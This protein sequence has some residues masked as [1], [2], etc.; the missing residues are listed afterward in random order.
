MAVTGV[1]TPLSEPWA[2]A[3]PRLS[4]VPFCSA[5]QA[6]VSCGVTVTPTMGDFSLVVLA[7]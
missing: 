1:V 4:T 2:V 5:S 6:P 7:G 3:V